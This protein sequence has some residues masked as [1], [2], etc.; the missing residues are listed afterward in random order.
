MSVNKFRP[1]IFVLPEDDA[2]RQIANGFLL[3]PAL[4]ER[5]IQ[6]LQPAGGWM[7]VLNDFK[8][9]QLIGMSTYQNRYMVLLIDFDQD[10]NRLAKVKE[11]IPD[12]LADRVFVL[13]AHSEP[14]DLRKANLGNLEDIGKKLAGDCRE[15]KPITWKHQLLQHNMEE[16]QRMIPILRP[17]LFP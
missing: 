14:E 3:D 7:N 15:N 4:N 11:V 9:N 13:G 16:L 17:I 10:E 6:I 1:H 2:N 5:A 12:L 8:N